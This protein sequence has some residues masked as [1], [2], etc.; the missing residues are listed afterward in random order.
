VIVE[1]KPGANGNTGNR[2]RREI[3]RR[4]LHAAAVRRGRAGDHAVG[5]HQAAVRSSKDLRGVGMLAY[6]PHLLGGASVGA[7]D[8]LKE[9]VALSQKTK[10]DF[11]VHRDRQR[12][13]SGRHRGRESLSCGV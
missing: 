11:A 13:A 4:R 7:R 8:N 3:A 12:A 5:L 9:L 10:I 6:S 1:N 2:C